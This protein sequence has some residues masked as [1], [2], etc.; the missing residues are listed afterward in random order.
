MTT[1]KGAVS[2]APTP[3]T[4]DRL[5]AALEFAE[6]VPVVIVDGKNPGGLL[7]REWQRKA[8]RDPDK[9]RQWFA[10]WPDANIG[11]VPAGEL[12]PVDVDNP[13]AFERL[14]GETVEA[15]PTPRYLTGGGPGRERLLFAQPGARALAGID[16]TMIVPGVQLRVPLAGR[17]ALMSLVPPSKHPGTGV[18]QEWTIGLDEAPLAQIPA[19]WLDGMRRTPGNP[20]RSNSEWS[21][22]FKHTFVAGCGVTHP[23]FVSMAGRLV[24]AVG[25]VAAYELLRCWNIQHCRPPKPEREIADAVKWV[26][27][28]ELGR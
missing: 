3:D 21:A 25:A 10:T 4:N 20:G 8:T 13:A 22:M 26:A 23:S 19:V 15:P 12:L 14:Q 9:V 2:A 27:G 16:D 24:P 28:K 1:G 18:T 7:G 17:G 5:A 11:I 6:I